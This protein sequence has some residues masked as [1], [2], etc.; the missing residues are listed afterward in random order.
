MTLDNS[1]RKFVDKQPQKS[2]PKSSPPHR[3]QY[4]EIPVEKPKPSVN[5]T[6]KVPSVAAKTRA[7][8]RPKVQ[9][10]DANI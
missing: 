2:L 9:S 1:K 3:Y 5:K 6:P 8:Q 4:Q 7:K 10:P